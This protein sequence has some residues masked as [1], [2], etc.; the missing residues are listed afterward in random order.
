MNVSAAHKIAAA[1][2]AFRRIVTVIPDTGQRYLSGELEGTKP[3]ADEPD[4]DH[5]LDAATIARL[6]EHRDRLEFIG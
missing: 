1:H 5:M 6:A 3:P 2:G 4:R